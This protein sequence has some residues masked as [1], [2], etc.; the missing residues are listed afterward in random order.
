MLNSK[1]SSFL[2]YC[3]R[4]RTPLADRTPMGGT[5]PP[6]SLFVLFLMFFFSPYLPN[7]VKENVELHTRPTT[8][9]EKSDFSE[10]LVCVYFVSRYHIIQLILASYRDLID[11]K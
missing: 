9:A 8:G 7:Q 2:Q 11:Q 4:L 6:A 3:G 5:G 1:N 10:N